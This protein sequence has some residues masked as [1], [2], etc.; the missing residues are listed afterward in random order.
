[1]ALPWQRRPLNSLRMG[2]P[3]SFSLAFLLT[4]SV[5]DQSS[6]LSLA[7]A[8][9]GVCVTLP[10]Q[11]QLSSHS[12]CLSMAS[13]SR[14][15]RP[16]YSSGGIRA[17]RTEEK[18]LCLA[19]SVPIGRFSGG[20]TCTATVLCQGSFSSLPRTAVHVCASEARGRSTGQRERSSRHHCP[21]RPAFR[22]SLIIVRAQHDAAAL[23]LSSA[24]CSHSMR[25]QRFQHCRAAPNCRCYRQP[26]S[27]P[28]QYMYE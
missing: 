5:L 19:A 7:R 22:P 24:F 14:L 17:A 2:T 12:L 25:F 27:S 21:N 26:P 9:V 18:G 1:M 11:R 16:W 8:P 13:Y 6:P 3:S 20:A 10:W 28:A 4:A 23:P 15:V